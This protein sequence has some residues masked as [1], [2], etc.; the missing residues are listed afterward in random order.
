MITEYYEL[1]GTSFLCAFVGL[2]RP[3]VFESFDCSLQFRDPIDFTNNWLGGSCINF[4]NSGLHLS[5]RFASISKSLVI[6]TIWIISLKLAFTFTL[7]Q[8]GFILDSKNFIEFSTHLTW[9]PSLQADA[10]ILSSIKRCNWIRMAEFW[11][12]FE[13]VHCNMLG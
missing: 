1:D 2:H 7:I 11:W 13:W 8:P 5:P 3:K 9:L 4:S 12:H 6:L 10:C